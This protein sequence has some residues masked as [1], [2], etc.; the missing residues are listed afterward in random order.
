MHGNLKVSLRSNDFQLFLL[1]KQIVPIGFRPN[2]S[3]KILEFNNH[4]YKPYFNA[5]CNID[6]I[7]LFD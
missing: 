3:G 6:F 1:F 4:Y 5:N 7:F 2:S